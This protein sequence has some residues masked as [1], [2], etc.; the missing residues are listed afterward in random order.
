MR[1]VGDQIKKVATDAVA[2]KMDIVDT[3]VAAGDFKT[4]ATLLASAGLVE[5]L[6]G[7]GPFTVFAPSD[8]AFAKL[9]REL[10]DSLMSPQGKD[11]LTGILTFHVVPGKV[12]AADIAKTPFA[13]TLQGQRLDLKS[14]SGIVMVDAATVT[15]AD[16]VCSN[17]VIH[18]IDSV[19]VPMEGNVLEVARGN[20]TFATLLAAIEAAGM[21]EMFTAK[22]PF[23]I[24][25]P[26][27]EAFR[28][29]PKGALADLLKPENKGQLAAVL[30]AH[31]IAG[32][33]VY[34]ND[35]VKLKEVQAVGGSPSKVE[36]VD[37]KVMIGGATV[38]KADVEASN[39]VIHAIN[40]V[41]LPASKEAKTAGAGD[42]AKSTPA[43]R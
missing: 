39:G 38:V 10:T 25:A 3:A 36:V 37:G 14:G 20:G 11:R 24:L 35:V 13:T 19:L 21:N 7:P 29:L 41:I 43:A 33:A 23:T 1:D 8:A 22:G 5:A 15:K 18:V 42:D 26:T 16:I 34:S 40:K 2:G 30:S 6:K 17:G 32:K 31:V 9:P 28:N 27:D 12:M 4:L